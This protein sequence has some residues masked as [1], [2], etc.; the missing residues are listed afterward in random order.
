MIVRCTLVL[1]STLVNWIVLDQKLIYN[2]NS[3]IVYKGAGTHRWSN[4]C[5]LL[6]IL[7]F[8][9]CL[10]CKQERDYIFSLL[11]GDY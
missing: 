5:S 3:L 4:F 11:T 7:D 9:Y 10:S 6:Y 8:V 1:Q 2:V